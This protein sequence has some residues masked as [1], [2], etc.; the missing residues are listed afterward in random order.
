MNILKNKKLKGFTLVEALVALSMFMIVST[1][2][3][4]I[5]VATIRSE[6]VA[7]VLLR[8]SNI[9]QN[10]LESIARTVRMGSNFESEDIDHLVFITEE[11]KVK[12]KTEYRYNSDTKKI[13]RSKN[14]NESDPFLSLVPE[15]INIENFEFK[16]DGKKNVQWNIMI[17]FEVVSKVYGKEYRTFIQTAVTPRLLSPQGN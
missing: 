13:E 3:M 5:Y 6:R 1:I 9:V 2:L 7:Y 14:V 16:V 4:N 10:T 17:K 12:F 15:N 11:S 8:D